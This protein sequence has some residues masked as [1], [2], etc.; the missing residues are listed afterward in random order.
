M[1]ARPSQPLAPDLDAPLHEEDPNPTQFVRIRSQDDLA[2]LVREVTQAPARN[3]REPSP[4]PEPSAA[5]APEGWRLPRPTL[6]GWVAMGAAF[7]LGL[8][9]AALLVA[10]LAA[11]T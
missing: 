8:F 4:L 11:S 7:S 1:S 5:P 9:V 3:V 10:W 2:R 6:W